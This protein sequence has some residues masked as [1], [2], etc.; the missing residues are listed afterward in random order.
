MDRS[1]QT[2]L[3]LATSKGHKAC[4]EALLMGKA[5]VDVCDTNG[6]SPLHLAATGGFADVIREL[7][8]HSAWICCHEDIWALPRSTETLCSSLV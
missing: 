2:P 7:L 5:A 8:R 6:Q 1:L 3:H 4:V